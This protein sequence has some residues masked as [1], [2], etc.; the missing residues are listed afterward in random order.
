MEHP[1][2]H[3]K[4]PWD[5][6]KDDENH[7]IV[8]RLDLLEAIQ[9]MGDRCVKELAEARKKCDSYQAGRAEGRISILSWIGPCIDEMVDERTIRRILPS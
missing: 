1:E 2:L 4:C 3:E 9:E 6:W 7:L 8:F 5:K